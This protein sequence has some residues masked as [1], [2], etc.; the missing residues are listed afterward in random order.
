MRRHV[1]A[2]LGAATLAAGL[3]STPAV[4]AESP[5]LVQTFRVENGNTW[6]DG[7]LTFYNRSVS[8]KGSH[9]SVSAASSATCRATWAYALD[10]D[11]HQIPGGTAGSAPSDTACGNTKSFEFALP[12]D[13]AGGA[14]VVRVCLDD[15]NYVDLECTLVGRG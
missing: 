9:R 15:G 4:A 8:V 14:A 13:V 5:T 1:A 2:A 10:A 3:L 7:T 11:R 12:A 6:T